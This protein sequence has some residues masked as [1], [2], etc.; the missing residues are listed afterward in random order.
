MFEGLIRQLLEGFL[1]SYVKNF[2]PD[3]LKVRLLKEKLVKLEKLELIPE[4]FDYLQLPFALKE[5]HIGS[6]SIE[7]L[8]TRHKPIKI[9]IKD[10]TIC[11]GERDD[12]EWTSVSIERREFAAKNAK[13]AAAELA[14]L[15]RRVCDNQAGQMFSSFISAKILDG[16]HVSIQNVSVEY[17]DRHNDL[18][19]FRFGLRL[20]NLELKQNSVGSYSLEILGLAFYCNTLDELNAIN[21][22]DSEPCYDQRFDSA[23]YDYMVEPFDATVSLVVNKSGQLDEGIPQYS[24]SAELT[25]VVMLLNET[26]L[27]HVLVFMDSLGMSAIREKYARYRPWKHPLSSKV[28]GWER[29]WWHYAQ[30]SVLSDVRRKLWKTSWSK[31]GQRINYRHKY[32]E[33]YMEK[34]AYL[35]GE[36]AVSEGS[37]QKLEQMERVSD[38]DDILTYRAIAERKRQERPSNI[39]SFSVRHNI[40]TAQDK[41]LP[42]EKNSNKQRGW[43]NWLSLGMLGAAGTADCSQFSGVVPDEIVKDIFEATDFHPGASFNGGITTIKD[44]LYLSSIKFNIHQIVSKLRS[45]TCDNEIVHLI[46]HGVIIEYKLWEDAATIFSS[47]KSMEMVNPCTEGI[48]LGI[49]KDVLDDA[50]PLVKEGSPFVTFQVKS[51]PTNCESEVSIKVVFLPFELIYDPNILRHVLDIYDVRRSFQFQSER[52]LSSLNGFEDPQIRL[53]SKAEYFFLNH[54]RIIMDVSFSNISVKI[55]S[56][57]DSESLTLVLDLG[58]LVF[59]SRPEEDSLSL[60]DEDQFNYLL[61]N[62]NS[63]SEKMFAGLQLQDLYDYFKIELTNIEVKIL[64]PNFPEAV[65]VVERF[66]ASVTFGTCLFP[67]EST[68]KNME[69]HCLVYALGVHFSTSIYDAF[70]KLSSCLDIAQAS[71]AKNIDA[72]NVFNYFLSLHLSHV[73]L[74]VHLEDKTEDSLLISFSMDKLDIRCSQEEYLESWVCMKMLEVNASSSRGDSTSQV[75]CSYRNSCPKR[76]FKDGELNIPSEASAENN[77]SADGCF[78]LH[79]QSWK[80]AYSM[81]LNNMDIHFYPRIIGLLIV[82]FGEISELSGASSSCSVDKFSGLSL[83]IDEHGM[84]PRPVLQ[85]YGFSNY[86]ETGSNMLAS[87]P[88]DSFPFV[89]ICKCSVADLDRSLIL[90]PSGWRKNFN[91]KSRKTVRHKKCSVWKRSKMCDILLEKSV[92]AEVCHSSYLFSM[93]INVND[94][95][96]HFHDSSCIVGSFTVPSASS[97]IFSKG[98]NCWDILAS[99]EG[100][101]FSS[102]WS[103]PYIRD[104]IWGP[105]RPDVAPILNLH[106]RK[107]KD[108]L[109]TSRLEICISVQHV[110]CILSSDYLAILIGYFSLPDWK[111]DHDEPV[112]GDN[113]GDNKMMPLYKFEILDS[114]IIIPLNGVTWYTLQLGLQQ[115]C[116][117]LVLKGKLTD[118]LD[119]IPK[120]CM[121]LPE[122]VADRVHRINV[123]GDGV[124]LSLLFLDAG[125]KLDQGTIVESVPLISELNADLWIRIPI[126]SKCSSGPACFPL[127]VMIRADVCQLIAEE[128]YF[129]SGLQS[130]IDVIDELCAVGRYSKLF[131]S[132]MLQFRQC[133]KS[134]KE[135][136]NKNSDGTITEIKFLA[137]SFSVEL[138]RSGRGEPESS[139]LIAKAEMKLSLQ[140]TLDNDV[141]T[142]LDVGFSGLSLYSLHNAVILVSGSSSD[143]S[144]SC[145]DIHFSRSDR[146]LDE[147]LIAIQSLDFWLHLSDWDEL[148]TLIGLFSKPSDGNSSN[149]SSSRGTNTGSILKHEEPDTLPG[150]S[151]SRKL[152]DS[153]LI[154]KSENIAITF[155]FPF[156]VEEETHNECGE[157]TSYLDKQNIGFVGKNCKSMAFSLYSRFSEVV[158]DERFVKIRSNIDKIEGLLEAT[159]AGHA[160]S[161]PFFQ[162]FQVNVTEIGS[163]QVP[164]CAIAFK[165]FLKKASLQLSDGR[166]SCNGPLLEILVKNL[167]TEVSLAEES[168]DTSVESDVLVYY[169][170]MHKV[171]WEPFVE[172]WSFQLKLKRKGEENA[173]INRS[174]VTDIHLRSKAQLNLNITEPLVEALFRGNEMIRESLH[175]I[176][177]HH[178]FEDGAI[179]VSQATDNMCSRKY[180][181]YM[182]KN[183]TSVPLLFWVSCSTTCEDD[184]DTAA[185]NKGNIVQPGSSIPI[186]IDQSPKELL[187]HRPAHSTE[188]LNEKKLS[189]VLHH[190]IS[191]QLDGTSGPSSPMSMDL[192]GLRYFEVDFSQPADILEVD[193]DGDTVK[194]ERKIEETSR[195]GLSG[196]FVAPVVFEVSVQQY[197]KLIRLYSTVV[198][199]NA[200][201]MPLELR[202]DIPFGVSPMVLDPIH[203]GKEFPLPVHLAESGQMRWRP[204]GT[205]Y[206]WSEAHALSNILSRRPGNLKSFVCYP[207]HPST[208]PFRCCI[209][210]QDINLP[211]SCGLRNFSSHHVLE[212]ATE[213]FHSDKMKNHFIRQVRLTT[214]F[215]VKSFLPKALSLIIESGGVTE[216]LFLSE[217]DTVSVYHIDSTHDLGVVFHMHG[218]KHTALK[219]PRAEVF[220]TIAKSIETKFSLLET[221][222]F[223]PEGLNGP[224]CI[225]VEKIMDAV[226]GSRELHISL[227]FLLYNC[228]GIKLT[229]SDYTNEKMGSNF[230]LPSCFHAL[231]QEQQLRDKHGLALVTSEEELL[232]SSPDF[233]NRL[234]LS[235]GAS[236]P[237]RNMISDEILPWKKLRSG[238][239]LSGNM[240]NSKA[241]A[242]MY[243]PPFSSPAS[244]LMVRL[245]AHLPEH[246]SLSNQNSMWSTPFFLVSPAGSTIV[247]VPRPSTK[248]AFLVSVTS[249]PV[250]GTLTRTRSVTIQPR[251]VISNACSRELCF[252]QKGTDFFYRLE[253]GQHSHLHWTDMTRELL[254]SIRFNEPGWEWSG[255]FLPDQLG[256]AQ[257]KMRNYVSAALDMVRVEVQNANVSIGDEKIVGSSNGHSGTHLILLSDDNTGYMPYRIDNFT[258]E[259][260]RIYQQKCETFET[261]VHPYTSSPYAWDEPCYPH[262]LIVE[263]PGER[264]L[265][266]YNLDDVREC[267]PVHL[268]QTF[269]KPQRR[270]L[271]S[272]HAE[273]AI[274]VLSIVDST[275]HVPRDVN[276]ANLRGIKAK[277]KLDAKEKVTDFT[278]RITIHLSFIGI[279]VI[280]SSPQE[281]VFACARD[282][283][284]EFQ[285]SVNQQKFS[286]Q[287]FSLQVDNQLRNAVYPVILSFDQEHR[288]NFPIQS[289]SR[290]ETVIAKSEDASPTTS[291]IAQEPVISCTAA[292]WRNKNSSFVS[293]EYI[294]LRLAPVRIELEEQVVLSLFSFARIVSLRI[295]NKN[296]KHSNSDLPIL[297]NVVALNDQLENQKRCQ[298]LPLVIPIGAPWQQIF[299][300][301]RKQKKIYV[302]VLAVAPIKLTV[303]FSSTPWMRRDGDTE[304]ESLILVGNTAFQRGLMALVNIEGAPIYLKQLTIVHHLASW[305]SIQEII[306]RHYTRQLLHEIYKVFGSAGVIGN[307]MGFA[308]NVGLGIKDFLS[309]PAKGVLQSPTG[310]I[311]GMAQGTKSLV[312]NTI[313]AVSNA[314]TQ[315][316]KAAH[317]GLVAFT[318]DEQAVAKQQKKLDSHSGVLNEFLEGLTG[319]LQ[320]PIKGAEKHGLPGV[321]SGIALGTAGL[322]ARPV[323]SILQVAGKTA[324]S[325]RNR[326]GPN[327]NRF[328]IR[329]PRPLAREIPLVPY[330]WEEAIGIFMLLEAEESK[331]KDEIFVLCKALK[332]PGKFIA[333]TERMFI[334]FSSSSLVGFGLPEFPGIADP[335]WVIEAEI[336]LEGVIH[337]DREEE[338]VNV[339]VKNPDTLLKHQHTRRSSTRT[340]G[341]GSPFSLPISQTSIQLL[342]PEEAEDV[343]QTLWKM[344]ELGKGQHWGAHVLHR[345][346]LR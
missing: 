182:L 70:M 99:V 242:H 121:I 150:S 105:V 138:F 249:R 214:P 132:D 149:I 323:A 124:S 5:G 61:K 123:F 346:T 37:I 65:S 77:S 223:Y 36:Q 94:I 239:E 280:N 28:R 111:W 86:Y 8:W 221:L 217:V 191:I 282:A 3:Q 226:C 178:L 342:N 171:M 193:M 159:A 102:S 29:I 172:P 165:V 271:L 21:V 154:V 125:G 264:V 151:L 199:L 333:I 46:S 2:E 313:F 119:G 310:L 44:K 231:G 62:L 60:T 88:V 216:S 64:M 207:S 55:P 175:N 294:N 116:C 117:S 298:I 272:V 32:V 266:S 211:T 74:D 296:M 252:K 246:F 330:S 265:G 12:C 208:G 212:N 109:Q 101:Q 185:I 82:F 126:M 113:P 53:L 194:N 13:L 23:K 225:T 20:S 345:T 240:D 133:K 114:S 63:T 284:I 256:D 304:V 81:S 309:V 312:N 33:L 192:V 270:L 100:L 27:R 48:I 127:S 244:E 97:L 241:E 328:R 202:F 162:I 115:L 103:T 96:A 336:G 263:V 237:N 147:L 144:P 281:L 43:L 173:L 200:T 143:A 155:H 71:R 168:L 329:L 318:F 160:S 30:E 238:S 276:V 10:V 325:I 66:S 260:L 152:D 322:V 76:P 219:F 142:C 204:L 84:M 267:I 189:G 222:T 259:R 285:Q 253:V 308:R 186:Y 156:W 250:T 288:G 319:F 137:N 254:V 307:P 131:V 52:V 31:F 146:D 306:V 293:F 163:A 316:S 327:P 247:A 129:L 83:E 261:I 112:Q 232:A 303:S 274:K 4:A 297:G 181:P 206:L 334:I 72:S 326:S 236:L 158:V 26:Q 215:I 50:S 289:K 35:F 220:S 47:V 279:S 87:I 118:A 141:P 42:D 56:S 205:D 85:K 179:L 9:I 190:M 305:E 128:K 286:L 107:G 300:L 188:K 262:R 24:I 78:L 15:S 22:D 340:R 269:E 98:P 18:A 234:N 73:F 213:F 338:V 177:P 49:R 184:I 106:I 187:R 92:V 335:D 287:V 67:D 140:V 104:I 25:S 195:S 197:S 233:R 11:I 251:Y 157:Q 275:H 283:K 198:L 51:S 218:F 6:L 120:E 255:S 59:K 34:L 295:Q 14:K 299:L 183:D 91:V 339:V 122:H 341:L 170:N 337:I 228:T 134:L 54:K 320:S 257:V 80:C 331:F 93:D 167:V 75:L 324:Q 258:M 57:K 278:E 317:Q 176:G 19:R 292:K 243:S 203:P 45:N 201:S 148:I 79:Y 90:G 145:L 180:A 16:I 161:F 110:C 108:E 40:D 291:E 130:F 196:G 268:P 227:P 89:T 344:I 41:Q 273:G 17:T 321:L 166:W 69:V 245:S 290:Q 277:R 38:V 7:F 230:I 314:A 153:N 301:A 164:S 39:K 343:L 58:N 209:S 332:Q 315:F 210:I 174:A 311:T 136:T 169:N 248:G 139:R 135:N 1:G 68:L 229:I 302:E 224:L 235:N 95:R